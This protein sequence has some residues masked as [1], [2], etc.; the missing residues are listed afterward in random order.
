VSLQKWFW[1]IGSSL[2]CLVGYLGFHVFPTTARQMAEHLLLTRQHQRLCRQYSGK[3]F[4]PNLKLAVNIWV[5][6]EGDTTVFNLD[7]T[8]PTFGKEYCLL[9]NTAPLLKVKP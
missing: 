1:F 8:F 5:H 2:A 6:V 4:A 3:K 7:R 9:T